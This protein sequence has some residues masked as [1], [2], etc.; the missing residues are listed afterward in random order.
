MS[1]KWFGVGKA[2][3]KTRGTIVNGGRLFLRGEFIA[4]EL[5]SKVM[6]TSNADSFLPS[7]FAGSLTLLRQKV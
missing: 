4:S 6:L 3:K 1:M 5:V 2:F 7:L